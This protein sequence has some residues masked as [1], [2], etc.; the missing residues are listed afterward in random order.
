MKHCTDE[1]AEYYLA[2]F[3]EQARLSRLSNKELVIECL[4]LNETDNP[5]VDEM[6]NRLYP[7]WDK[8]PDGELL[9]H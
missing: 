8:I 7:D 4:N 2:V 6:M 9:G 5:V 1:M 3:D